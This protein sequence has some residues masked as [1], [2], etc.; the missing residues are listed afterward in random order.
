[1]WSTVT[2][3]YIY[4]SS[5]KV[6]LL[7]SKYIGLHVKYRYCTVHIS[8]FMWSTLTVQCIYRSSCEVPLLYSTYIGLHVKYRYCTVHISVFMWSTVTV[9]YI[10]RSACEVPLLLS[11]FNE[12]WISSTDFRKI[13]K[14]NTSWISVQ[15]KPSRSTRTDTQNKANNSRFSLFCESLKQGKKKPSSLL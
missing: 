15:R 1:M 10:Y 8:V 13:S 5:C 7:Y 11:D 2:L 6:P 14:Y 4:R 9:Q 3:Q 12:T